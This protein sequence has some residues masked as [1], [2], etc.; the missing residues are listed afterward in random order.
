MVV[1]A[2]GCWRTENYETF[3]ILGIPEKF[4]QPLAQLMCKSAIAWS[5]YIYLQTILGPAHDFPPIYSL[6]KFC[7]TDDYEPVTKKKKTSTHI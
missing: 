2:L 4:Y 5:K 7:N 6:S 3:K 1:G